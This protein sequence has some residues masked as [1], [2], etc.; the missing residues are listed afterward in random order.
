MLVISAFGAVALINDAT[1]VNEK[2]QNERV[3]TH[4]VF[5]ED[6]TATWCG[7]CHYAHEALKAIYTS[8]DYPFYYITMVDDKNTHAAARNDEYNIYGFPTVFFDGGNIV[9]VGG[10]TGNE[11][12]YRASIQSTGARAVSNID[13]SLDVTWLGNA[14]M[15][16]QAS[17][18]NNEATQ[19]NG[20][21]RVYVT[22]LGSTMGWKDTTGHVYTF[23][24]LD[25]AFNQDISVGAGN[26][27]TQSITWDGHNYNDGYGNNFGGIVYGNIE[28]LAVVF[29]SQSHQG[30]AHPPS[31]NPFTAYWVDDMAG[32]RVGANTP[33]N[34]PSTPNPAN[35]STNVDIH[36]QLSFAGGDVNPFDTVT[37]DVYFG[38]TSPPPKVISNQSTTTYN[39]G[40]LNLLTTYYW[41][42]V[43]WDNHGVSTAG[44]IWQFTTRANH[45]PNTPSNPHPTN[46]ATGVPINSLLSWTGGDPDS[47]DTVTYNVYFGTTNPP[48]KVANNQ[49]AST[50]NP[51][52]MNYYTVYYWKIVSFDSLGLSAEGPVWQFTTGILNTA[53]TKPTIT[54]PPQGKPGKPYTYSFVATDPEQDNVYYFVD[55]GDNTTA[56]WNGP[57]ASGTQVS[58]NH[59][60]SAKGSYTIKAKAKDVHDAESDW[61]TL[62]IKM[63]INFSLPH[64]QFLLE[65]LHRI[66]AR[67]PLLERLF[68]H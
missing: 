65:F 12:Q 51:G 24:F 25:Y 4:T 15:T 54:G 36:K 29:N 6:A 47:G 64:P 27:W 50:Y 16:I 37:Y 48:P 21:I 40:T 41:K 43:S 22:E 7:Y 44:P 11:A 42:I 14:A 8:G 53:P 2:S 26:T 61:G 67:F 23:P 34:T 32:V 59:T 30:Y 9:N 3:F 66:L 17:V 60:W 20:H 35:G 10:G 38:T 68:I 5:A 58:L 56:Q 63:P 52:T 1:T 19:Y 57:Y 39:P 55:W 13:V 49:S 62:S 46:S 33:P 18:H 45:P 31:G 28:V